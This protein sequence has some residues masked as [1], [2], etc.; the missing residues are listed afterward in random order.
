MRVRNKEVLDKYAIKHASVRSA[1]QYWVY[2]VEDAEW[3]SHNDLK[4]VFPSADYVGN[5]RYVFNIQG[6]N[7]RLVVIVLF[8]EGYVK[9]RFIGTHAEYDKIDCKTV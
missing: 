4:M 8:V 9:I 5:S 1:L 2:L 3:R 6:N 7:Y